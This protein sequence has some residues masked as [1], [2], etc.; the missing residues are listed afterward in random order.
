MRLESEDAGLATVTVTVVAAQ[1]A[2]PLF[3]V[4]DP[5]GALVQA[6]PEYLCYELVELRIETV[7]LRITQTIEKFGLDLQAE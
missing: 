2:D 5:R 1:F 7:A 6:V 3:Q 4:G